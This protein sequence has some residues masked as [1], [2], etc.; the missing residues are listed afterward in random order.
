MSDK[1]E[2]NCQFF[3][4]A[5]HDV[6]PLTFSALLPRFHTMH[7]IIYKCYFFSDTA[8]GTQ[9]KPR[10]QKRRKGNNYLVQFIHLFQLQKFLEFVANLLSSGKH[11]KYSGVLFLL[12]HT[13]HRV[14]QK[15]SLKKDGSSSHAQK[16][17]RGKSS[18]YTFTSAWISRSNCKSFQ[19]W[20]TLKVFRSEMFFFLQVTYVIF[21]T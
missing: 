13:L 20:Q 12:W 10:A 17:C 19:F 16:R 1:F 4:D 6:A 9:K 7:H 8:E 14:P 5:F 2:N 18:I 11:W 3:Q 21:T 15:K